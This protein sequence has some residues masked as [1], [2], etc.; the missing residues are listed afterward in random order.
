MLGAIEDTSSN[1]I[2]ELF[3]T[4]LVGVHHVCKCALPLL[5]RNKGSYIINITSMAA[6][7]GL[8]YRGAYCASKFAVEGYTEALSHELAREGL[9]V[10][11]L[12]P[13]DVS[14]SINSNRK[15]VASVSDYHRD[16]HDRIHRQ[17]NREVETGID[18]R[19]VAIAVT[20]I[21]QSS[22]PRLRYRVAQSKA[23]LAYY[24]MRLLPDRWFESI[25]RKHY[26]L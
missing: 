25:I 18:P 21:L 22:R 12:E 16:Y 15:V 8:P 3:E 10:V 5:R 13:G 1:D 4:N 9:H 17:V 2:R 11:I 19:E 6:Q 7:M 14:T 26:K 24:L 23:K 20:K